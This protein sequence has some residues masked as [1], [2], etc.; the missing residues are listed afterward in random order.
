MLPSLTFEDKL[1]IT[2]LVLDETA[3]SYSVDW[4]D[5]TIVGE[6]DFGGLRRE[7]F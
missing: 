4:R 5:A 7:M 1:E 2:G 6:D 3:T